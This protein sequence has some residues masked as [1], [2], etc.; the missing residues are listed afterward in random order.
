MNKVFRSIWSEALGAWVAASEL[1]RGRGKGGGKVARAVALVVGLGVAGGAFAAIGTE[2]GTATVTKQTTDIA[3]GINA[4]AQ[5]TTKDAIAIGDAAKSSADGA[6]AIGGGVANAAANSI[7]VGN[8]A[9]AMDAN[10]TSTV[11]FAPNGGN[12]ANSKNSFAFNPYGTTA[13]NKSD[14]SINIMGTVVGAQ[15]GVAL[16]SKANVSSSLGVAI[17]A[18]ASADYQNSVAL[19]AGSRTDRVNSVSVGTQS[20]LRQIT[21]VGNGTQAN[22]AVTVS[23][24]QGLVNGLGGEIAF[25]TKTGL[26]SMPTY[27]VDGMDKMGVSSAISALA[28]DMESTVM[29]DGANTAAV[30]FTGSDGTQLHTILLSP[31][32]TTRR[33]T[34]SRWGIASREQSISLARLPSS[35]SIGCTRLDFQNPLVFRHPVC[36]PAFGMVQ[37]HPKTGSVTRRSAA[38]K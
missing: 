37:R 7:L 8:G 26:Y 18:N 33:R 2:L 14:D 5:S 25:D 10:S 20:V 21:Q 31:M 32:T 12:V 13:T 23:Q 6:I 24:L 1:C 30:T 38:A 29:Y 16:G 27:K 34:R 36:Q 11:F 19:G 9:A 15:Y 28:T 3:I 4:S 22:D 35:A 17:G